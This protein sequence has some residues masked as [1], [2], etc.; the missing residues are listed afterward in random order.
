MGLLRL[1]PGIDGWLYR[2]I[3][4]RLRSEALDPIMVSA[5]RA[6]TKSSAW[7]AICG[8]MALLGGRRARRAAALTMAATLTAQGIVN[9]LL[10]PAI[11]RQRPYRRSKLRPALLVGREKQ[12][13]WPSAHAA[14]SAAAMTTLIASYP[15]QASG[16][17]ALGLTI[18]YSRVYVG[19]HYPFDVISGAGIG[20]GVGAV[21]AAAAGLFKELLDGRT[22]G[23]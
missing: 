9:L 7:I 17:L 11:R 20:L 16:L 18:S 13:S 8:A 10:K 23:I 21:Y 19:V 4:R 1:L 14:S 3:H 22:P 2:L 5:T 6:G 15:E 12:H